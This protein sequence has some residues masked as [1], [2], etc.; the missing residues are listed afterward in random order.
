LSLTARP[1][2]ALEVTIDRLGGRGD[3]IAETPAG[4]VYVPNA[5]PGEDILVRLGKARAEGMAGK[6]VERRS[7]SADRVDPT[8]RHFGRCGGC[9]TQH[10][11]QSAYAAWKRDLLLEA[12]ARRGFEDPSIVADIV[13]CPPERRRLRFA[14]IGRKGDAVLGFNARGSNQVIDLEMCSIAEPRIVA[15][16]PA[17]R[18]AL[19][20]VLT[21]KMTCDVEIVAAENG[22]DILLVSRVSMNGKRRQRLIDFAGEHGVVRV[23]FQ[24]DERFPPETIIQFEAPVVHFGATSMPF[25]SGAFLQPSAAGEKALREAVQLLIPPGAMRIVELFSGCGAFGI[26]LAAAGFR[27]AAYEAEEPMIYAMGQVAGRADLG[28][29]ISGRVRDLARQ[30][31]RPEEMDGVD[32]VLLD[33]PRN[34]ATAQI[35]QIADSDVPAVV[36]VS[37]NPASFARDA[38]TLADS[39]YT[40]RQVIPVDQFVHTAHLE[41]VALFQREAAGA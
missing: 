4:P 36:Y 34:G 19:G 37:C 15:V 26:P 6:V 18:E 40:L 39:G 11:G 25:P 29:R 13:L 35:E 3:G 9:A 32:L 27:V 22:L 5:L 7:D 24:G 28:G 23:G 8:C 2:R 20:D 10:I 38:G 16:L 33:P 14:A 21:P 41:L 12:L 1:D 30:P 17:L 31:V